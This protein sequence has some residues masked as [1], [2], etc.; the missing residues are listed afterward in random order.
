MEEGITIERE[1][2]G[3]AFSYRIEWENNFSR[4]ASC[5]RDVGDLHPVKI[6][7]V[8]DSNVAPLYLE[9]VKDA[10]SDFGAEIYSWVFPAGERS[11]NLGT[12]EELLRFLISN[13][14]QRTDLLA[15]LG[16]GVTGDLTGF[17]AAVYLRGIDF[18]QIPTTLLA[19][20]DS[21]VG[22]KTG[23]DFDAFK[24]MVGAFHQ[25]RLVYMNM[26]VLSTLPDDQ[27]S[28]GMGEVI[29]SAEIRS[30]YFF[31]KLEKKASLIM[32]R[33]PDMMSYMIRE[34]CEIKGA[35]VEEDPNDRG[36]RAIL[37]FGHTLGHAI[38]KCKNF[39][40]LHGQ[41]V[42]IGTIGAG[43][44]SM[45]RGLITENV[46]ERMISLNTKFNLAVSTDGLTAEQIVQTA[47]SDKKVEHGKL[48]FILLDGLGNAVIDNSISEKELTDA[49]RILTGEDQ[50]A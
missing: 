4:L 22:G 31:R 26:N 45:Q 3:L 19:Q 29:K 30:E 12:V 18:I 48:K 34:C 37:N 35:V 14:F 1:N 15:A 8:T 24:N 40:L 16:G 33:D 42:A 5:I 13:H 20:V 17:A 6:C 32:A 39:E 49:A 11:K 28:S 10:L 21:S 47:R 36:I 2:A 44:L 50:Y 41:C 43:W 23:V 27:F 46:Y 7:I 9:D 38:E 25:P